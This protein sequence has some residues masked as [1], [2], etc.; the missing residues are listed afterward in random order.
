MG[1]FW[2]GIKNI[3]KNLGNKF[4]QLF[5]NTFNDY[6]DIKSAAKNIENNVNEMKNNIKRINITNDINELNDKVK[7]TIS[8]L[9]DNDRQHIDLQRKLDKIEKDRE[10]KRKKREKE[11]KKT[12]ATL[13][14]GLNGYS[15]GFSSIFI[16]SMNVVPQEIDDDGKV[17]TYF[18]VVSYKRIDPR[19]NTIRRMRPYTYL[20]LNRQQITA[21][22][23]QVLSKGKHWNYEWKHNDYLEYDLFSIGGK[24]PNWNKQDIPNYDKYQARE[25]KKQY[26][27]DININKNRRST[28][29]KRIGGVKPKRV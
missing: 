15:T 11:V 2:S 8:K 22:Q 16:K 18:C 5:D 25:R 7:K 20:N 24:S 29:P 6:K 17:K 1:K 4:K 9:K 13:D 21:F 23:K 19:S 12:N 26:K 3:F 27:R 10:N 14:R 28:R